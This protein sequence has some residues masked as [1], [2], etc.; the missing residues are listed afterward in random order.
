[1]S[2]ALR[3]GGS[4]ASPAYPVRYDWGGQEADGYHRGRMQQHR[5][6]AVSEV[7]RILPCPCGRAALDARRLL[8]PISVDV[9]RNPGPQMRRAQWNSGGLSQARRVAMEKKPHENTVSFC[10][11]QETPGVGGVWCA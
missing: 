4:Q 5:H 6:S 8:L 10:L 7:V 9:E 3:S 1:M 11:S 2:L